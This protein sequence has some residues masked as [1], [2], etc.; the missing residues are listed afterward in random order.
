MSN[1]PLSDSQFLTAAILG[2]VLVVLIV[3]AFRK[4][5]VTRKEF[6][7][8][9]EHVK[10]LSEDVKELRVAEDRRFIQEL[11]ASEK[12]TK[13]RSQRLNPAPPSD[14][15]AASGKTTRSRSRLRLAPT[16]DAPSSE[17]TVN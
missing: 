12:T 17:Q 9:Q 7:R 3:T 14:A 16:P 15:P 11:K 10:R 2:A 13:T 4:A 1:W 5:G 6:A 8:L